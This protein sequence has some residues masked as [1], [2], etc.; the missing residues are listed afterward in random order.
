MCATCIT[1][2]SITIQGKTEIGQY[3]FNQNFTTTL[4]KLTKKNKKKTF[5]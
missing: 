3:T 4:M 2:D 5:S 1:V